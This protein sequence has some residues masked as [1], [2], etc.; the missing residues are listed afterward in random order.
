MEDSS[1]IEKVTMSN[2]KKE[3]LDA[4]SKLLKQLREKNE[5]E[6]KPTE[7]VAE[8]KVKEA[9]EKADSLSIEGLIKNISELKL[10]FGKTVTQLSEKLED[11]I[12][13]YQKIKDAV[14]AKENELQEIFDIQKEASSLSALIEAQRQSK[15][16]FEAEMKQR[17]SNLDDEIAF[18]RKEWEREK[19]MAAAEAKE[20]EDALKKKRDRDKEEFEYQFQQEKKQKTDKFMVEKAALERELKDMREKAEKE[21]SE[22]ERNLSEGEKELTELRQ[23]VM[24]F[25]NILDATVEKAVKDATE[26]LKMEAKH[27]EELLVSEVH[28][29]KKVFNIQIEA[30]NKTIKEQAAQIKQLSDQIEKSYSQV[31]DIAV[32][33]VEGAASVKAAYER[34]QKVEMKNFSEK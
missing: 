14:E 32:K 24:D 12:N 31:Q 13:S 5:N 17:K 4:Y 11:E 25:Q 10:Q 26:K 9:V 28:G 20:I 7:K 27:K 21:F 6:I 1:N 16:E 29:E 34:S 15:D 18:L 2:T 19:K 3:M 33:A 22:R 23:K 30:L 8:K